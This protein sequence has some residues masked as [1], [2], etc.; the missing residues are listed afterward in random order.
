MKF[1]LIDTETTGL[2]GYPDDLVLDIG[3]VVVD[4][5]KRTV[6]PFFYSV[7]GYDV[8]SWPKRLK[9]S[10]IFTHSDL[11]VQ[12]IEDAPYWSGVVQ[13]FVSK[14]HDSQLPITSYNEA[15]D[16]TKFLD[17]EPWFLRDYPR[18]PCVMLAAT[19]FMEIPSP[20][21]GYKWPKLEEAYH[22]LCPGDPAG[23]SSGQD[24]RALSDAVAA[25][26]IA[27]ELHKLGF[28]LNPDVDDK[29][30]RLTLQEAF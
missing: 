12:E 27:I 3:S 22:A 2:C 5:K 17:N 10:W 11:T 21:G 19:D 13:D 8:G 9:D 23:I 18:L 4:L 24:H 20:Y 7:L 6:E 14:L 16:F 28:Y 26:H 29:D 15:Y 30:C 1:I 25:G